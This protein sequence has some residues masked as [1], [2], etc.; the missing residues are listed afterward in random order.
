MTDAFVIQAL[1]ALDIPVV[2]GNVRCRRV[3]LIGITNFKI[4]NALL[5][6][7]VGNS[8]FGSD[9]AFA[10]V[11]RNSAKFR[12]IPQNFDFLNRNSAELKCSQS[13]L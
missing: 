7:L 10:D 11:L 4:R 3:I 8:V 2:G 6:A 9:S 5:R 12:G 1:D 13:L